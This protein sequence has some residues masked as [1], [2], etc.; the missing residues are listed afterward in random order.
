[1]QNVE[2]RAA[3]QELEQAAA[4]LADLYEFAPIG[5]ASLDEGGV[6]LAINDAAA[7]LLGQQR[8]RL[9]GGRLGFFFS[10]SDRAAFN[11]L[12][13]SAFERGVNERS[14]CEL[15]LSLE[16][17]GTVP[18]RLIARMIP[19]PRPE[20]LLALEDVSEQ[21]RAKEK[22]RE[23]NSQLVERDRRKDDFLATLSHELRNPLAPIRNASYILRHAPPGSEQTRRAKAVIERQ[24]EHLTRLVNDLLDVTRIARGKIA[25]RRDRIDLREVVWRAADDFRLAMDEQGVAFRSAFPESKVWAD[26]DPTRITQVVGNLLHNATKFTRRGGEVT[27]S[28]ELEGCD[29]ARIRVRDTGVGIDP[30]LLPRLFEAFVQGDR[31]LARTEG[32]LGLGLALVKGIAELHGGSVH[33]ES[34]GTGKGAEFV[35]RLPLVGAAP[36]AESVHPVLARNNVRRRVLVVDDNRDAAESLA[37]LVAMLGHTVEIAYDGTSAIEKARA[38]E[39]DLVLCDVGLPGMCGHE[40]ARA[41]REAGTGAQLFAVSG[42]AQ[43]EDVKRA[44]ESGFDG[45]LA[46]PCDPKQIERLLS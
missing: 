24:T 6:I 22:M 21:A 2:L 41:L 29:A 12:I 1:M 28:L 10:E 30:G 31:T 44:I 39:P 5:Y 18:V 26:A 11:G 33:A 15:T 8:S 16:E 27:L 36:S 4:R 45:H 23:L 43:P 9:T 14:I 25:L 3:R 17:R 19:R 35:V 7:R 37:D 46:K 38:N 42:Y 40:V 13:A 34:A 20:V 32:G